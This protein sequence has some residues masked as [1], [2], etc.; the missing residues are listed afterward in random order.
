[1]D[2]SKSD[3]AAQLVK[4][5]QIG[6]VP[7]IGPV[8]AYHRAARSMSQAQLAD[9]SGLHPMVL[10]KIERGVQ[11]DV[12]IVTIEKIARAL[13]SAGRELSASA[14]VAD[15]ERWV[16]RLRVEADRGRLTLPRGLSGSA[17]DSEP[18]LSGK[19]LGAMMLA[20]IGSH[21]DSAG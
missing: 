7:T 10:S 12:G 13:S 9:A 20:L 2:R 15:A 14:I 3:Q 6:L 11:G 1:M 4:P 19:V 5:T 16:A 17:L 8:I 21:G 18:L